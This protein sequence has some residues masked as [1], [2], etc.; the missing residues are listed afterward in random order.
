[1][2]ASPADGWMPEIVV[3]IDFG[4]TCTGKPSYFLAILA[5]LNPTMATVLNLLKVSH[6]PW[7]LIGQNQ[8]HCS[9]GRVR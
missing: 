8:R 1:M 4:M 9:T 6:T 2:S 3:G 7:D 5:R